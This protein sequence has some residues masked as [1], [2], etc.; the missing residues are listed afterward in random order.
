LNGS[1]KVF[2]FCVNWISKMAAIEEQVK[3][4]TPWKNMLY[5]F[6]LKLLNHLKV[7][8]AGPLDSPL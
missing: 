7:D 8:L 5:Y 3:H 2:I 4:R 1:F 6:S